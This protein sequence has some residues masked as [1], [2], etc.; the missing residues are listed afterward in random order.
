MEPITLA[1]CNMSYIFII[2]NLLFKGVVSF[3]KI[4]L[5]NLM[6]FVPTIQHFKHFE[7]FSNI[8]FESF[9][10]FENTYTETIFLIS[11]RPYSL[12]LY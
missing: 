5:Y 4:N 12:Q 8:R 2:P 6:N 3:F 7:G 9:L 11:F 10:L 1:Q